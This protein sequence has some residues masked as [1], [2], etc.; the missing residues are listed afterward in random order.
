MLLIHYG[1]RLDLRDGRPVLVE[2]VATRAG[3]DSPARCGFARVR[4][5]TTRCAGPLLLWARAFPIP[6]KEPARDGQ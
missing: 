4:T 6:A 2:E 5:I 1:H 3:N